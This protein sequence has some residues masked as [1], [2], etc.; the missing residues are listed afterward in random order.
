MEI[1]QVVIYNN[2]KHLEDRICCF[3]KRSSA[4]VH[5]ACTVP[6]SPTILSFVLS[7]VWFL[8]STLAENSAMIPASVCL[9]VLLRWTLISTRTKIF[10]YNKTG[11]STD[12]P[13]FIIE[14]SQ[15][16]Y[17][18]RELGFPALLPFVPWILHFRPGSHSWSFW[19]PNRKPY[20]PE[21]RFFQKLHLW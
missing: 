14:S 20:L 19:K 3:E 12:F 11:K 18:Q 9:P 16:T 2:K 7:G 17:L 1:T 5:T 15:G 6:N 21:V 10:H 8:R 4:P 13:V